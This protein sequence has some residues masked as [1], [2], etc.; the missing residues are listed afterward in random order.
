V[1]SCSFGC[2]PQLGGRRKSRGRRQRLLGCAEA[3]HAGVELCPPAQ[4]QCVPSRY[5]SV[6]WAHCVTTLL[7]CWR[8]C[9]RWLAGLH[10]CRCSR[11]QMVPGHQRSAHVFDT[12]AVGHVVRNEECGPRCRPGPCY[13]VNLFVSLRF[14]RFSGYRSRD[15][16][17]GV[18]CT[19][20]V[21][22]E[23]RT[24]RGLPAAVEFTSDGWR[25][26]WPAAR[27]ADNVGVAFGQRSG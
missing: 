15:N 14:H 12:L 13:V 1:T 6:G 26:R 8:T 3:A 5:K 10:I 7:Q 22:G 20:S 27:V 21:V 17:D 9:L 19:V 16:F 25:R 11:K 2:E 18:V 23:S 24:T 4:K